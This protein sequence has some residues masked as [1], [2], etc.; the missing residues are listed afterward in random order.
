MC[1]KSL[2]TR[3]HSSLLIFLSVSVWFAAASN[4]KDGE[5][6]SPP[7][8][9]RLAFETPSDCYHSWATFEALP[10]VIS[11]TGGFEAL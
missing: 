5:M 11:I 2:Q 3:H 10:K 6:T 7:F 8:Q 4:T 1:C 9:T